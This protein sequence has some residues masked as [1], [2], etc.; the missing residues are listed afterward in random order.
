MS[1]DFLDKEVVYVSSA[2]RSSGTSNDFQIDLSQQLK[3]PNSF[4]SATLLNFSCPKSYYLINTTNNIFNVI[5]DSS[6]T[7][8]TIPVGNYTLNTIV[9][10]LKTLLEGCN[11]TYT[12]TSSQSTG[13]LTFSVS[14]NTGQPSFD[15]TSDNSPYA[16]LGF[17]Q[18]IYLF[19]T[20][21][22][23]SATII[24]LQLTSTIELLTDLVEKSVLSVIIP[25]NSDFSVINYNE[26]NPTF[27]SK[28]L[29]GGNNVSN[30]RFYL[31]DGNTGQPLDLN[32]LNF[33]FTFCL[34]KKNNYFSSMIRDKQLEL[35]L[36]SLE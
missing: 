18:A 4:D 19:D 9:A 34:Y 27:S 25:N 33:N 26:Y 7:I 35:Y 29:V 23:T 28:P 6:T 1:A 15:F 2:S 16:I 13:K 10:Q 30:A 36:K 24:N 21:Q 31:I 22:L 12:V 8:I 5:E 3:L 32:G 20:N 14:G 17:E 11:W